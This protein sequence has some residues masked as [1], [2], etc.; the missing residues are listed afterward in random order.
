MVVL[1]LRT[2][3]A[4]PTLERALREGLGLDYL[5]HYA[6]LVNAVT[7]SDLQ[8][9]AQTY[10]DPETILVTAS[11]GIENRTHLT[12]TGILTVNFVPEPGTL[13]LLASGVAVLAIY[14]HRKQ[15]S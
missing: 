4:G 15:G 3:R 9:M 7:V 6:G 10:L 5:E 12:M 13:L 8:D 14:G 1:Q 2:Y 11:K